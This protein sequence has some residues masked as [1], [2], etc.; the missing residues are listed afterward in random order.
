MIKNL[1]NRREFL[2]FFEGNDTARTFP[3]LG[4]SINQSLIC[5]VPFGS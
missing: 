2:N 4:F 3:L 1:F 5:D